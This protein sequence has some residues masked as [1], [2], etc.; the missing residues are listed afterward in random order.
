M[1]ELK[2][3]PF[4]G[5]EIEH[6]IDEDANET[7]MFHPKPKT[8]NCI[9]GGYVY[10][11][12]IEDWNHRPGED[13][14]RRKALEEVKE[15]CMIAIQNT[16]NEYRLQ[17]TLDT[18]FEDMHLQLVDALTPPGRSSIKE[19]REELDLLIDDIQGQ[20]L[21]QAIDKLLEVKHGD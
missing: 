14:A 5:T 1:N 7:T 4:C 17:Y 2:P 21:H 8:G 9:L 15:P 19:G 18:T 10:G 3:C 6:P 13:A 12:F 11:F 16:L 20:V